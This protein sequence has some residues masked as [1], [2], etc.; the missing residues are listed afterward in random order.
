[1]M[2]PRSL[3]KVNSNSCFALSFV[4]AALLFP[5][6][7]IVE[8]VP[9]V[10]STHGELSARS[11]PLLPG[12]TGTASAGTADW[13]FVELEKRRQRTETQRTS[14]FSPAV[15][16]GV[17]SLLA[18]VIMAVYTLYLKRGKEDEKDGGIRCEGEICYRI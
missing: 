15:P 1:M 16:L 2:W 8:I 4:T 18:F 13:D 7:A 6:L 3:S 14:I 17:A 11:E 12:S 9:S 10:D 5:V